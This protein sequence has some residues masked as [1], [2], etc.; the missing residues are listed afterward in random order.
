MSANMEWDE[1]Y[2]SP[3]QT[4]R[5]NRVPDG[6]S[7]L[8]SLGI[9]FYEMRT[10]Q[11]PFLPEDGEEWA[12]AHIRMMPL[13]LS[14]IRPEWDGPL[15]AII[16]K[17]LAKSPD[18][19]YQSAFGLL[20]DLKLCEE[21][22]ESSGELTS[23][24]IGRM[25]TIRSFHLTDTLYGRSAAIEQ[26]Q[27]GLEQAANGLPVFRWVSGA[28][29]IGKT[30]LVQKLRQD[31]AERGG[32]FIE[33]RSGQL[34]PA[35]PFEPL[36]QALR[37]WIHQLWSEPEDEIA[38][39]KGRLQAECGQEAETI[40]A[41]LPEAKP[42]F[43]SQADETL[44]PD[45][46]TWRRLGELLPLLIRC[47]AYCKPPLV[48]FMD[49]LQ[50]ADE[51]TD[52]VI[53]ALL[54]G[55]AIPGL[56]LIG[57]FRTELDCEVDVSDRNLKLEVPWLA[58]RIRAFAAEQV[59]LHP[60]EYADVRQYVADAMH[61]D[62][63]RIRLLARFLYD[64]TGGNPRS[65]GL[66]LEGWIRE[67]KLFFDD[68]QRQWIWDTEIVRQMSDIE[69]NRDLREKGFAQLPVE[70]RTLL[71]M[72]AAIGPAFRL[73]L[74]A[75]ISEYV[76]EMTLR[77][78]HDAEVQGI[79]CW[80]EE[81]GTEDGQERLYMFVHDHL[82]QLAYTCDTDRNPQRH[83][84]IGRLLQRRQSEGG[85]GTLLEMVDHLNRGIAG[86]SA[87][88][89]R[90]LA[91]YNLEAAMRAN[92]D[93][94][95][96]KGKSYAESGL[97]LIE[98][99]AKIQSGSLLL[100]IKK[101]LVQLEYR[102]GNK[103]QAKQLLLDMD[104]RGGKLNRAD[105]SQLWEGLI[106]FHTFD[107]NEISIRYGKEALAAHGWKL[108]EKVSKLSIIKEV[109]HT[110]LFLHQKRD[111]LNAIMSN[112]DAEYAAL[113]GY[114][115]CLFY[116][117]LV[118]NPE[119][120]VYL[121]ARFIRYGIR[122]GVNESLMGIIWGYE[123][124]VQRMSPRYV[125]ADPLFD[126]HSIGSSV[127]A[128]ARLQH[129]LAYK[130]GMAEQLDHPID[131][132]IYLGQALRHGLELGEI[133]FA[134]I[135]MITCLITH[136]RDLYVL[137]D[138]LDY[139]DDHIRP[140]AN[141]KT[142]ELVRIAGSYLAA[143]QDESLQAGFVAIPAPSSGDQAWDSED[144]YSFICK[145]EVAYLSGKYREALYWA[146]R[147]RENELAVDFGRV[148]KHR[149]YEALAL[150]AVYPEADAVERKRIRQTI[151]RQ[152]RLMKMRKGFLGADSSAYLLMKAEGLRIAGDEWGALHGYTEAVQLARAE[153]YGLMEG[154]ACERL[155]S[156]YQNDMLSQSGAMIAAM[157]ACTAYSIWG[158]TSKLT[159]IR[160]K[161][162]DLLH[163][164]AKTYGG[165]VL[166]EKQEKVGTPLQLEHP[167]VGGEIRAS[168][169]G[170][171]L[172]QILDWPGTPN[173]ADW[174]VSF[175]KAAIRQAGA[176][177][178]AVLRCR[179]NGFDIASSSGWHDGGGADACAV[180]VL[181]HTVM[182]QEP[183]VLQDALQSHFLQDCYIRERRPRSLLVMP[184]PVPG[185]R[186]PA[187]L[188]LE[189]RHVPGVFTER[190]LN[191]LQL[192]ATRII[193]FS[194]LVDEAE[195]ADARSPA[196]PGTAESDLIEPLTSREVE[197]LAAIAEGLSN[198]DI[199]ER[200]GIAETTVK[201]HTTRIFGKLG[202]K[203]RGQ[204]VVRAKELQLIE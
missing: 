133:A 136:S 114:V 132:S 125:Q 164:A 30:A 106:Q 130:R 3:E 2:Q 179:N 152:L 167:H 151:R 109:M 53:R 154:I 65:I 145:L 23:L 6:R 71:A 108:R 171:E 165:P 46:D 182:T 93:G 143:L 141:D 150:A 190:D 43:V 15:Q 36:L 174:P 142:L 186:S 194:M 169:N 40:V 89:M 134:N 21:M 69:A 37:Q 176:D 192:L 170:D 86:M 16:L 34:P 198:K 26:M 98:E 81:T 156:Y 120:L 92:D 181:R 51:D 178:G 77:L 147:G 76:P 173:K 155:A 153:K 189:N 203:R 172:Q 148:W 140:H 188:Y 80:E 138:L 117:L 97:R 183:I 5:I 200:F 54:L 61:E 110:R 104:K 20:D 180:S 52:A 158:I 191:V 64:Q 29:G 204:A 55:E 8:Y 11:L 197:V 9:L 67:K 17:L 122:K 45:A 129:I 31:I 47:F 199:A 175:L 18:E 184:V 123:L 48:L 139:F 202:A 38:R 84:K 131:A 126:T 14:E 4:G 28:E 58:D 113:C 193:Y 35:K 111:K 99:E 88:E 73:S 100:R 91:E 177:R 60:L 127:L 24:E 95:Y 168:A 149:L 105:R 19:R 185:E 50:R 162:A 83:L 12:D 56:F 32:R 87:Q 112:H 70:T 39:L 124:L 41:A 49:N 94:H 82:H 79:I 63:A 25:D 107:E 115:E 201:T 78:L 103:E 128:N 116:P 135:A 196:S 96:W 75:E 137:S 72:A 68:K 161:H 74:L 62:S 10:G 144:N 66:L 22:L 85:Y 118:H 119:A 187:L 90:Q 33:G 101:A 121:Y 59:V 13:P 102:S 195:V 7:D 57:A 146:K 42:L 159:Q 160:H 166:E 163:L 27:A 44:A 157:D 1:V